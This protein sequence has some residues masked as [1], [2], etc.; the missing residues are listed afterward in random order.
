MHTG[1]APPD[2]ALG[3]VYVTGGVLTALEAGFIVPKPGKEKEWAMG[4]M[5]AFKRRAGE[6]DGDIAGLLGE[7]QRRMGPKE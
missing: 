4:N 2:L 5:E 3:A 7:L 1:P 6:G